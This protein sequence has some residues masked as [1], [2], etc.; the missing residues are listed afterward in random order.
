MSAESAPLHRASGRFEFHRSFR[1]WVM[2]VLVVHPEDEL[3]TDPW[4]S[5]RWDRVIDFGKTGQKSDAEA[6]ARFG[7]RI[8][9]LNE[10]RSNFQEMCRVREL[11]ALGMGRLNDR[12]GLDWWELTSILLHQQLELA[13]LLGM[14]ANT[15]KPR[16]EVFVTRP[17]FHA[18]AL[19]LALGSRVHS[20]T[21]ST[22]NSKRSPGRYIG[23]LK[24]FPVS[25]LLEIF[26]DKTDP[27]YQFRG[28]FTG[29]RNVHRRRLSCFLVPT[30][31][32]RA[33]PS[34]MP[35][36]CRTLSSC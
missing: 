5:L 14:L 31:V 23:I 21:D 25:Q 24:K 33:L 36:V 32:S 30:S 20:F 8:S 27:G 12:L 26:W 15:I 4:G 18:D 16:D 17:G 7:C 35:R 1:E 28:H 3:Q 6:G 10:F 19:R 2:R 29:A 9:R 11:L 22:T 13:F 34:I